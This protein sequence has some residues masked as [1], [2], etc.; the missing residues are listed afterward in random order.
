MNKF[1]FGGKALIADLVWSYLGDVKQYIEPFI[2]SAAVLLKRPPTKHE[3]IYEIINDLDGMICNVWRSITFMPDDVVKYCDWPT[4]HIDL[5]ARKKRMIKTYDE[6]VKNLQADAEYCDPQ[7]AG[8]YIYCASIWIGSG[9]MRPNQRPHLTDDTGIQSQ[10]PHLADDTGIQSGS[11]VAEWI[12]ALS[13]RLRG[14]KSICGEWKRVCGGNW[15][16]NNRPVGMFFDPPYAT[17]GRDEKIY[18]HDSTTVGTDV[19]KW[20]LERGANPDY[21]IVVAGYDD[22]Y[23]TLLDNGWTFESWSAKG[24]YGNRG[25]GKTRGSVNRHRERLFI[26][27]HCVKEQKAGPKTLFGD[28]R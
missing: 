28:K 20:C 2:G 23:Q 22:E 14:V 17:V 3:K 7:L 4:S 10:R 12:Q 11:G 6:L 21:R 13:R 15:Q 8:Y 5:I 18:H 16:A 27:P 9:L 26:S 1:Y 25:G 24:G 19:E